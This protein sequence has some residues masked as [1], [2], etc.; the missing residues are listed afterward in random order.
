LPPQCTSCGTLARAEARFC[1]SCGAVLPGFQP[2]TVASTQEER[3]SVRASAEDELL[4]GERKTVTALFADIKGSTEL[5]EGLD[6]EEARAIVDPALKIMVD[7]VRRYNGY[8]VQSTGDGIFALFGAPVAYED[9]PQHA[10]Y[11]ALQ[12]QQHLRAYAQRL[13]NQ[14]RPLLEAR[15]GVNTGEVVVRT[16][17]TGGK[18][19]YTP[20]G[21]T[22]NLAARLQALAAAG[23]IAVSDNTRK[24]VEGYFELRAVGPKS[25][26]GI[27]EPINVYEVTG[28]G[29]LRTHFQISAQ[30]GLTKVVGRERE[31]AEMERALELARRGRG[32]IVAIVAEAGTG[33]SRLVYE[34]KRLVPNDWM[35][36]EAYSVSHGKASAYQPVL[37]LMHGYFGIAGTDERLVRCEKVQAKVK[38]L[39]PGLADTLPYLFSLLG[40]QDTPDPL[41]QLD[42]QTK[43]RGTLEA[44]KRIVLRESLKQPLLIIFEDL[45]WIDGETQALLDLVADAL[46]NVQILLLVNYRPEYRHEWGGKSYYTR[47]RLD[48][49]GRESTEEVLGTLLGEAVELAPLKRLV[50]EKTGGNPFFIE[51]MVQALFDQGALVRDG[52][53]PD[54]PPDTLS[55]RADAP[56][57]PA[58]EAGE[59]SKEGSN[60][61]G[62][63]AKEGS[64]L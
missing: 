19:E 27:S 14:G 47:L 21:H 45:H 10:L 7:A 6:P 42:S 32:Q 30:R 26:R 57:S 12:M 63:E 50:A 22:A 49:L 24:L 41:A 62:E 36:L 33:K 20:I 11:A 13:I 53:H 2:P 31:M 51:E 4:E 64:N 1:D 39:D 18:V 60:R 54:P 43:R 55:W 8:T 38:A 15:F 59:G 23:S 61:E 34:F 29:A 56:P 9:H 25:V 37:D 3:V 46:A 48:P 52:L 16:V 5:M 58:K 35:L 28:T 17:E 40:I 44:L